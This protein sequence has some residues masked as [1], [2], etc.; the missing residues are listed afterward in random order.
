MTA[1]AAQ[2]PPA[3]AAPAERRSARL[4]TEVLAPPHLVVLV[5]IVIGVHST[6]SLGGAGWGLLAGVFCGGLPIAYVVAGVRRGRWSDKH[7]KIREQRWTPLFVTLASVL[8]GTGLLLALDAPREVVALVAAMIAGLLLTMAV[9]VWWK[10]SVHTAV[11]S[12]IAVVV[13]VAYG[14][15]AALLFLGVAAVGWSRVSLRDHTTAQ[16]VAGAVLG[17]TAAAA[18]FAGLR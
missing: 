3:A 13:T 10:V 1:T 14:W 6:G 15:W 18:V 17:G 12:G 2:L 5:L 16:V 11:A 8:A 9:T 7:L 4:V